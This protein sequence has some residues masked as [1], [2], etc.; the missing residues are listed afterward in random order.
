MTTIAARLAVP[1]RCLSVLAVLVLA[2]RAN[3]QSM[4]AKE[5]EVVVEGQVSIPDLSPFIYLKIQ[6]KLQPFTSVVDT[7]PV[8]RAHE[9]E[10]IVRNAA[11]SSVTYYLVMGGNSVFAD[12]VAI[13]DQV[14][15]FP[16]NKIKVELE[17]G[18]RTLIRFRLGELD[19]MNKNRIE[20]KLLTPLH[21]EQFE[22]GGRLIQPFF[23]GIFLFMVFFNLFYFVISGWTVY[24]KYAVYILLS[25]LFFAHYFGFLQRVF[26]PLA[27]VS[28]N[29]VWILSSALALSYIIFISDFGDFQN[30]SARAHSIFRFAVWYK[31]VQ[32]PIETL[33]W[34]WGVEF[35]HTPEYILVVLVFE[36]LTVLYG[37]FYL[38]VSRVIIA[39]VIVMASFILFISSF[40]GQVNPFE[41]IDKVVLIE[42]GT[43]IEI[44]IFSVTLA[45]K[46]KELDRKRLL[47]SEQLLQ[48]TIENVKLQEKLNSELGQL[49]HDRTASLEMRN[50]ENELLLAE[51][52]HRVKNNLQIISSLINLK[53]RQASQET[54]D[55]LWQINNRIYSIGLIHEK[56][57]LN[58][59]IQ[60]IRLD[61][62]LNEVSH[63]A[64]S[65]VGG[66]HYPI[67]LSL[68]C[69]P[70]EIGA[71]QAMTCGLII[72]E[73]V[74]NSIK[75][76][77]PPDQPAREISLQLNG[78][79][80]T[81]A[82]TV[83]D[84]GRSKKE[85]LTGLLK[86][87]F[88]LRFVEQLVTTKLNGTLRVSTE[89][90]FQVCIHFNATGA[91]QTIPART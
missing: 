60:R 74:T 10:F 57:Y 14:V 17:P 31:I 2:P 38:L 15:K 52:H 72:S 90:G 43:L 49:V 25:L 19:R 8:Q 41:N 34:A 65:S 85:P 67:A 1:I 42:A 62:Y 37:F 45:L 86:K 82:L 73:L 28:N 80:D 23:I 5:K 20:P 78:A 75:Y 58:K 50:K 88:G 29:L 59:N 24:F 4:P 26:P 35:I 47:A 33:L 36:T 64:L 91:G 68:N 9:F 39:R 56:L 22:E 84:N 16:G 40:L 81:V 21:F 11:S 27:L 79:D 7:L 76:A 53:T 30:Q 66:H 70:L 69:H 51:V 44:L 6:G 71:D 77:F 63:Q 13:S 87:S 32:M 12:W 48:K 55:V 46:A 3:A 18:S 89:N 54:N 61:E 83:A